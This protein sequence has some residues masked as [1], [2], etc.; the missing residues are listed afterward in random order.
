[1]TMCGFMHF[2]APK[3]KVLQNAFKNK[4]G[5]GWNHIKNKVAKGYHDSDVMKIA[6]F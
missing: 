1:M 3:I 4:G 2:F 5:D 6:L